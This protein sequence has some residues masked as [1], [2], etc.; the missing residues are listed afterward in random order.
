[1]GS[2]VFWFLPTD[3]LRCQQEGE[4]PIFN[5][6]RDIAGKFVEQCWLDLPNHYENAQLGEYVVMPNHF[7]GIIMITD[8][9]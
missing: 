6:Q 4:L 7:H 3:I 2:L 9:T 8:M 1:M 5:I